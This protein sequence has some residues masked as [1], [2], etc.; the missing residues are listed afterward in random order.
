[1]CVRA[2]L[3]SFSWMT[4]A[5]LEWCNEVVPISDMALLLGKVH[6]YFTPLL[7][8]PWWWGLYSH[9]SRCFHGEIYQSSV[10]SPPKPYHTTY[11]FMYLYFTS[12]VLRNKHIP[13]VATSPFQ[14]LTLWPL[15]MMDGSFFLE[16]ITCMS[17]LPYFAQ[18][19]VFPSHLKKKLSIFAIRVCLSRTIDDCTQRLSQ[20]LREE[21]S[22][23]WYVEG[24]YYLP[25]IFSCVSQRPDTRFFYT[26]KT[27]IFFNSL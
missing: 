3:S 13:L 6:R 4:Y 19:F 1:M 21:Y 20:M 22:I 15:V 18:Y 2:V 14:F 17:L 11:L 25:Q 8:T 10:I 7:V 12:L 16:L 24:I 9:A 5:R 27:D 26:T 23:C